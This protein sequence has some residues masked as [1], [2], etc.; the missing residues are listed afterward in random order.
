[1]RNVVINV[2]AICAA[3]TFGFLAGVQHDHP[4][5]AAQSA[6]PTAK[7]SAKPTL[8]GALKS[9]EELRASVAA[10]RDRLDN[11]NEGF[12]GLRDRVDGNAKAISNLQADFSAE[13]ATRA[14]DDSAERS[15]RAAAVA[16]VDRRVNNAI[17]CLR[18]HRHNVGPKGTGT[19]L[20]AFEQCNYQAAYAQQAIR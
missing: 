16:S 1:M 18:L 2:A 3:A 4:I 20:F 12:K 13:K 15:A 6:T 19:P 10:Q 9:I 8:E 17:T 14:G 11:A 7:P 5:A